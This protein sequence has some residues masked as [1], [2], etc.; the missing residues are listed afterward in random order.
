M[1]ID[2]CV[3]SLILLTLLSAQSWA[4]PASADES[5]T[6]LSANQAAMELN[7]TMEDKI[8]NVFQSI[9]KEIREQIAMGNSE[10]IYQQLSTKCHENDYITLNEDHRKT[11]GDKVIPKL[12]EQGYDVEYQWTWIYV[13]SSGYY[14][15]DTCQSKYIGHFYDYYALHIKW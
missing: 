13:H 7:K 8:D 10:F 2:L 9:M 4:D 12:R 14:S 15:R 3:W 6:G 11:I 1:R 5:D